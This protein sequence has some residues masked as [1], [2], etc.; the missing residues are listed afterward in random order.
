METLAYIKVKKEEENYKQRITVA[1][2]VIKL[3][4]ETKIIND[5]FEDDMVIDTSEYAVNQ[6]Y[7][8]PLN[9]ISRG[10]VPYIINE[11]NMS[12]VGRF[13]C[14]LQFYISPNRKTLVL[15][16][17]FPT[18]ITGVDKIIDVGTIEGRFGFKALLEKNFKEY[19]GYI[20]HDQ[21][22]Y[23]IDS[24][25]SAACLDAQ[26]DLV[27]KFLIAVIEK[28]P[29]FLSG[30]ELQEYRKFKNAYENISLMNIS[31]YD[32]AISAMKE[33]AIIRDMQKEYYKRKSS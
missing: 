6:V 5:V 16:T 4:L 8:V 23:A 28:H 30:E 33:K 11:K 19:N 20:E 12:H 17:L 31:T 24:N 1:G 9:E 13:D 26:T 15:H 10:Y 32:K 22:N 14:A 18:D 29:E 7:I 27:T 25:F 2:S 21:L 3:H